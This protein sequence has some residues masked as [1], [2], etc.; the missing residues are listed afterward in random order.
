MLLIPEWLRVRFFRRVCVIDGPVVTVRIYG[1]HAGSHKDSPKAPSH[2]RN[3]GDFANFRIKGHLA[4]RA[5]AQFPHA[6]FGEPGFPIRLA[7]GYFYQ[8]APLASTD[9]RECGPLEFIFARA[10]FFVQVPGGIGA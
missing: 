7:P 1:A 9:S 4:L 6:Q 3:L 10:L 8:H 2:S 5:H